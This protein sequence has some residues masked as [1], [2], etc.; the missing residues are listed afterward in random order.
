MEPGLIIVFPILVISIL[1]HVAP[2]AISARL[3]RRT[4]RGEE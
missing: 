4:K 3:L 1:W 2:E